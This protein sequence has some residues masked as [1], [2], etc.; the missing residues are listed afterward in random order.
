MA[1][2]FLLFAEADHAFAHHLAVQI[3]QRGMVVWPVPDPTLRA[4]QLTDYLAGLEDASHLLSIVPTDPADFDA[5]Q[6]HCQRALERGLRA[7]AI[8][9]HPGDL[10]DDLKGCPVVD[11]EGHFLL[12]FEELSHLLKK[13]KAPTRLLTVEHP[14][15]VA[16]VG[17]LPIFLPSERCWRD[18]RL[19]INYTLP[20]L[21]TPEELDTRL[22]AFLVAFDF[23]LVQSAKKR[24]RGQRISKRYALFDPRR[25][26]HTLT[27]RRRRGRSDVYYRMTRTQVYHWFPAHYR[28]LDREAAAL[29]RYLATGQL[30]GLRALVDLQARRARLVSWS[31]IV[32]AL[33]ATA[34]IALL[35]AL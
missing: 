33:L 19:R 18:D 2:I 30:Q 13:S 32:V 29:Y 8:L 31:A 28:A 21:L 11:F 12:A 5:L 22:P 1:H 10:P 34:V 4:E 20:I 7:I 27:I 9:T 24:I 14:P 15:P 25:A 16:N 26:E 3:E 6:P 35:I 17:L 23:E